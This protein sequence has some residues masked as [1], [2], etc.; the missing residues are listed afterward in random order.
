MIIKLCVVLVKGDPEMVYRTCMI[1]FLVFSTIN[2]TSPLAEEKNYACTSWKRVLAGDVAVPFGMDAVMKDELFRPFIAKL[3]GTKLSIST[4]FGEKAELSY[5]GKYNST[6]V[7][8]FHH[9]ENDFVMPYLI[10]DVVM[11]S[12]ITIQTVGFN[13][14]FV[15]QTICQE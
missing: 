7:Y 10:S 4:V 15:Y 8:V 13:L 5:K 14:E 1:S 9:E 3:D 6:G 11:Q 12:G 2:L